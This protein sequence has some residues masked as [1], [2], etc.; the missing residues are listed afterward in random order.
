MDRFREYLT[1]CEKDAVIHGWDFSHIEGKYRSYDELLGWDYYDIIKEYLKDEHILLDMD[2]GGGEFLLKLSHPYENTSVTEGYSPNAELCRERLSPLG[3][4]VYE[5]GAQSLPFDDNIFDIIINRHGSFSPSEIYRVLKSGGLFI[6]QQVGEDNEREVV[7]LLLGDTP[8]PFPG[9]NLKEQKNA[10]ESAGF[11]IVKARESY[12][13]IEFY[14][15]SA[16]VWFAKIIEW[17]FVGF[18]VEKCFERL[19]EAKRII[20]TKGKVSGN[21]HRYMLVCRKKQ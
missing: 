4:S 11:E 14:D 8:K 17:E 20:D 19:C 15:I 9:M 16:L 7:K 6:T 18:S 10:F 1:Q 13:P 3:I 5:C 12:V 2:T 21:I